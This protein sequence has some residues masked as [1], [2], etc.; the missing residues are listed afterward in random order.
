MGRPITH[1]ETPVT[2]NIIGTPVSVQDKNILLFQNE[3]NIYEAAA[4][5]PLPAFPTIDKLLRVGSTNDLVLL[6]RRHLKASGDLASSAPDDTVFDDQL[7]QSVEYFQWRHGLKVDGV[8]G[9]ETCAELNILPEER[10]HQLRLNMQRWTQL[11]KKLGNRFLLVN[12]PEYQLHVVDKGQEVLSMKVIVGKPQRPTPE[13]T[14]SITRIV[15]NPYWNVPHL[16]A[17]KDIVPKIIDN[18]EYLAEN[19]IRIYNSPEDNARELNANDINWESAK[20]NGFAYHFRQEPGSVN[21]LGL[22]KFEFYNSHDVYLHDT[23]SKNL[24]DNDERDLSSGCV[25]LEKPFDLVS[26]FSQTDDNINEVKVQERLDKQSIS[27][28][29]LKEPLRIFLVYMTSWVDKNDIVHYGK[30]IYWED[31]EN[32]QLAQNLAQNEEQ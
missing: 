3:I 17:Q 30:D 25:R 9:N 5:H 6:L 32:P 21:A 13:L 7:R 2:H 12:I 24:F 18:P 11:S 22:V 27:Y 20:E 19:K 15:F 31:N 1:T 29:K 8:V 28:Y 16:I 26:Y 14:S 4:Q 23:P 10:I